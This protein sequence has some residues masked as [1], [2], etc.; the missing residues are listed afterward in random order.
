[1]I[2]LVV[3]RPCPF[4]IEPAGKQS[5][6]EREMALGESRG[7]RRRALRLI[8]RLRVNPLEFVGLGISGGDRRQAPR[9]RC[10][11]Q[12]EVRVGRNGDLVIRLAWRSVAS[13]LARLYSALPCGWR[14]DVR[15]PAHA[16]RPRFEAYRRAKRCTIL[17]K[18]EATDRQA[19]ADYE[20]AIAAD[21]NFALA[22]CSAVAEPVVDRR[23]LCQADELKGIYAAGDR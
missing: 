17:A 19:K 16:Q 6:A 7:D 8:D 3:G 23:R 21:P 14:R 5:I 10:M 13:S 4:G 11:R 2:G 22:H 20:I 12:G 18:D 15:P 9:T 1:M